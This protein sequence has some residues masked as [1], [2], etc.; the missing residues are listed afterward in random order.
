M[1][2]EPKRLA[3]LIGASKKETDAMRRLMEEFQIDWDV[4]GGVFS[5]EDMEMIRN[6][7]KEYRHIIIDK[8]EPD[9]DRS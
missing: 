6:R 1:M 7:P 8:G 4:V 3:V 5:P 2:V 9:V